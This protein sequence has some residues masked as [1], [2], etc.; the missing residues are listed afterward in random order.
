MSLPVAARREDT[1]VRGQFRKWIIR[2]IDSWFAFSRQYEFGIEMEDII[3]VTGC[4][5]TISWANIVFYDGD[6]N[7]QVALGVQVPY[8]PENTVNWRVSNQDVHGAVTSHR[9]SGEVCGAQVVV[10]R[11][12]R[13]RNLL[14]LARESVY[15]CPRISCQTY[16]QEDIGKGSRSGR[17]HSRPKRE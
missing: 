13:Y 17:T 11:L 6:V 5:R 10:L 15:I 7:T 16:H 3:L 9:S 1:L 4:H 2:H 8:T 12:S 14:E